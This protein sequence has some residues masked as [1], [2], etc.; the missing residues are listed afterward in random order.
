MQIA[1]VLSA[2]IIN[3]RKNSQD[4]NAGNQKQKCESKVVHLFV[5]IALVFPSVIVNLDDHQPSQGKEDEQ[6]QKN[7]E[8]VHSI[9]LLIREA[10]CA[11]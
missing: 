1:L 7:I 8:V 5:G 4:N 11:T 9:D 6:T 2:G 10:R 3:Q